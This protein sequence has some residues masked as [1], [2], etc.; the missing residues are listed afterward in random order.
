MEPKVC[1]L[2]PFGHMS[3]SHGEAAGLPSFQRQ[4]LSELVS[5][6]CMNTHVLTGSEAARE[7]PVPAGACASLPEH[8]ADLLPRVFEQRASDERLRL[9]AALRHTLCQISAAFG[10]P[11]HLSAR[12]LCARLQAIGQ[13][14]T[15]TQGLQSNPLGSPISQAGIPACFCGSRR[16]W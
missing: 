3:W 15:Q 10:L 2:L 5:G 6:P 1:G 9:S 11:Q 13:F 8:A 7:R 12:L 16:R 14:L 4:P